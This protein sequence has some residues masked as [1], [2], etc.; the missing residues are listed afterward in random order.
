[1]VPVSSHKFI[2]VYQTLCY[3]I[4]KT[5]L[6]SKIQQLASSFVTA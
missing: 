6:Q 3:S 4:F 2:F 5:S 1:M